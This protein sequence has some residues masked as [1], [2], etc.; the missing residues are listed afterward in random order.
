MKHILDMIEEWRHQPS[1]RSCHT[2]HHTPNHPKIKVRNRQELHLEGSLGFA[3]P[4]NPSILTPNP[5]NHLQKTTPSRGASSNMFV[6]IWAPAFIYR[7]CNEDTMLDEAASN[8]H[9]MPRSPSKSPLPRLAR[10][11]STHM[12]HTTSYFGKDWVKPHS[13]TVGPSVLEV[14]YG[15]KDKILTIVLVISA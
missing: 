5:L 10:T 7:D 11:V 8:T 4:T 2:P 6:F 9:G 15:K 13:V 14:L 3:P 1:T 12:T